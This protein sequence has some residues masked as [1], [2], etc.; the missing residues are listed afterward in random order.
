MT[1]STFANES[2]LNGLKFKLMLFWSNASEEWSVELFLSRVSPK[3]PKHRNGGVSDPSLGQGRL[4]GR[5]AKVD[6]V[7]VLPLHFP[8]S[9]NLFQ[10]F[11]F[12]DLKLFLLKFEWRWRFKK[13]KLKIDFF[14]S[15]R[16]KEF[17]NVRF[18]FFS[19]VL[20]FGAKIGKTSEEKKPFRDF[21]F[22][23]LSSDG[24]ERKNFR[25]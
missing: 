18:D 13:Q 23:K 24:S 2:T 9:R 25:C 11:F 20:N 21:H 7:L 4:S 1:P 22:C 14:R 10:N 15:W 19:I 3:T 16:F 12:S 17:F 8:V 5:D 6:F